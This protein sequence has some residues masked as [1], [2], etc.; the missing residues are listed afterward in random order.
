MNKLQELINSIKNGEAS[1]LGKLFSCGIAD[2]ATNKLNTIKK[3][4]AKGMFLSKKKVENKQP[5]KEDI[6]DDLQDVID[7]KQ[8]VK[9][10]L[11]NGDSIDIDLPTA[12][13]L[14]TV[15]NALTDENR[16]KM[17]DRMSQNTQEFLKVVDFAW[18]QVQ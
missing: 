17:L 2:K 12:N 9:A 16:Q 5:I 13:V 3:E 18:K 6:L 8:L 7:S 15:I 10:T 1:K 4:I 11:S 14:L